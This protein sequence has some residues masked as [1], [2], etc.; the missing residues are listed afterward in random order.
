MMSFLHLFYKFRSSHQ[1][2]ESRLTLQRH[3]VASSPKILLIFNA[4]IQFFLVHKIFDHDVIFKHM[5]T[6]KNT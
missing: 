3:F 4:C 5:T 2:K 1:K 6:L